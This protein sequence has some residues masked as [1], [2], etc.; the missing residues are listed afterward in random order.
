MNFTYLRDAI[1]RAVADMAL[2]DSEVRR[3]EALPVLRRRGVN[4]ARGAAIA[5]RHQAKVATRRFG[6]EFHRVIAGQVYPQ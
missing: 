5:A 2:A 6:E 4:G 3:R 1:T